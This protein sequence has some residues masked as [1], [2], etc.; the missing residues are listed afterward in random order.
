MCSS[1]QRWDSE[2]TRAATMHHSYGAVAQLAE[3][4]DGIVEVRGSI[5]LSSTL[6][7]QNFETGFTLGGLVA[8][9]G[10]FGVTRSLPPFKD[11]ATR[12]RFVFSIT[13]ASRD[14]PLLEALQS[15]LGYGSILDRPAQGQWLP[16]STF[17]INS[18]LAHLTS[19]I[20]FADHFLLP[21]EKR[22]QFEE[23]RSRFME[24]EADRPTRW[25]RG[26]SLC[27]ELGC[28]LPVRGRG[29]CRRH[30]Y[31]ATGY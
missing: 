7:G 12:L 19:T 18:R 31:R 24:H 27:S 21:C 14:R 6:R 13:M 30:Y 3:R 11:G 29:L 22:K 17:T 4:H 26:R 1:C 16:A 9:E 25:G 10:C 8:G 23:W 20:P 2:A 28:D 15:F 5:P